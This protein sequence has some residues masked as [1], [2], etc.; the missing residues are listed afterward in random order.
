[1]TKPKILVTGAAG[2]T[3]FP[4]AMQLLEK[5]FS[6]R[7]LVRHQ[8][9]RD[10]LLEAAGAEMVLGD[11]MDSEDLQRALLGVQRAYFCP[12]WSA[13]MLVGGVMFALAANAAKLESVV[14]LGQWLSSPDHP[15]FATRQTWLLDQLMSLVPGL[16]VTVVNPGWFADNYMQLLEPVAQLGVL[17]LPLGNGLN[18]PPSNEDIA[19]VIVGVLANPEVHVGRTYRPTGPVLLSPQE[20][21]ATFARVLKRP[22]RYLD[23]PDW[24]MLKALRALGLPDFQQAQVRYY[25]QDYRRNAFAVGAP[26]D[27]VREVGGAEPENF[28]TIT[29]RHA[30]QSPKARRNF[31]NRLRAAAGFSR[32]LFTPAL[33]FERLEKIQELPEPKV[34]RLAMDSPT[35]LATHR[36]TKPPAATPAVTLQEL[37]Q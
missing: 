9:A 13:Q 22:V 11:L 10:Q 37:G 4:A 5:G 27:A 25:V 31:S 36:D 23:I 3:G 20:I 17:P 14:V 12:P 7:A 26:T 2:N 19:R 28:E 21:A 29:K 33:D 16:G 30:A 18:A 32:I 15:S 24:M 6:V 8:S 34:R 1:M 35:W